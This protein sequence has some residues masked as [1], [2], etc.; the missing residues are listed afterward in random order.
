M[1]RENSTG[2]LKSHRHRHRRKHHHRMFRLGLLLGVIFCLFYALAL[3]F[4]SRPRV[5]GEH[6]PPGV[7]DSPG[8]S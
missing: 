3:W 6:P 2:T 8:T 7:E 1:D 4:F 5:G